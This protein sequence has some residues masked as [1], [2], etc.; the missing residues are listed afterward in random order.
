M[1]NQSTEST[2]PCHDWNW[3]AVLLSKAHPAYDGLSDRQV[4]NNI[5]MTSPVTPESSRVIAPRHKHSSAY[6]AYATRCHR[7]SQALPV[8]ALHCTTM[9][10]SWPGVHVQH[11][12]H[13][14]TL[15]PTYHRTIPHH[16]NRG[17]HE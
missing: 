10:G 12:E 1:V 13:M 5:R 14:T 11:T 7:P 6:D 4:Q 8:T 3:F 17:L 16:D 2:H 15:K 9:R